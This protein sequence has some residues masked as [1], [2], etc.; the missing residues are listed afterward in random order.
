C[1]AVTRSHS[2]VR[3]WASSGK[4]G[5][6]RAVWQADSSAGAGGVN[7][8]QHPIIMP[9]DSCLLPRPCPIIAGLS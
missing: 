6:R 7:G 1:V 5:A 8:T 9:P 2:P 4:A 3:A